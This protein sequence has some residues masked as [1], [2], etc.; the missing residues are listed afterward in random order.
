MAESKGIE[1]LYRFT[2]NLG[3]ANL[4]I[5]SLSTLLYT[6]SISQIDFNSKTSGEKEIRTPDPFS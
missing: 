6:E 2:D 1:P 5:T 4:Y 3:L